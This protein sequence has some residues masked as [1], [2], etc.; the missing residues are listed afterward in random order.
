MIILLEQNLHLNLTH[1]SFS[2]NGNQL[3]INQSPDYETQ[4]SYS[5]RLKTTDS[6]GLSYEEAV[7]LSVNDTPLKN[8]G[9]FE[10]TRLL[11]SSSG[12]ALTTGRDGSIYIA[13]TTQGDL[14]GQ[15]YNGHSDAFLSKFNPFL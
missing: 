7:D 9:E 2:I 6:G 4:S 13:G 11:D 10:W 12:N 15:T 5:I 3:I 1:Y 14:D 8:Q